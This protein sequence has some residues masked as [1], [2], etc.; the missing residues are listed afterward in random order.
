MATAKKDRVIQVTT[1]FPESP[2]NPVARPL[3]IN[4]VRVARSES[5]WYVDVGVVPIDQILDEAAEAA[6]FLVL[7][8][9]VMSLATIKK[10]AA[11]IEEVIGKA[12]Q[13]AKGNSDVRKTS[14]K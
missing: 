1:K 3:F 9:M 10:L 8:R 2:D 11:Q 5:D 14:K 12:D 7:E 13:Q 6:D 4:N